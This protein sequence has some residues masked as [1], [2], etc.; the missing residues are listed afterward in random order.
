MTR[1]RVMVAGGGWREV[2]QAVISAVVRSS[3]AYHGFCVAKDGGFILRGA[4]GF[5]KL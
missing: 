1:L 2:R 5:E 3:N 4:N